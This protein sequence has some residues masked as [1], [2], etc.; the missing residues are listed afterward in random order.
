LSLDAPPPATF[1]P[2]EVYSVRAGLTDGAS[3]HAIIS[4]MIAVRDNGA[5]MLWRSGIA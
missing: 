1:E 5:D 2:G 3:Q 4:A